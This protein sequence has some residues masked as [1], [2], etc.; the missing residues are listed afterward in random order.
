MNRF[1]G[2]LLLMTA[3][4][5]T[6]AAQEVPTDVAAGAQAPNAGERRYLVQQVGPLA[7][8]QYYADGF[9]ELTP[10]QRLLAYYLAEAGIAG[11]PIYYDQISSYGV[12]LK[13]LLEGI[14]TH[15]QGISPQVLEKI[16]RYTERFWIDHGNYDLDSS[17][18]FLPEFT[19]GE[20][21]AAAHQ[22]LKN[23]ANFGVRTTKAL[24]SRLA[25]L[26]QP[27]FDANFKPVLTAKNPPPGQDLLAASGNNLYENVK[28]DDLEH[29]TE[30]YALNSRVV[31]RGG[32]IIEEVWRAGT[33]DG[34]IPRDAMRHKFTASSSTWKKL[35]R[36]L[37]PSR[38]TFCAS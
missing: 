19:S 6:P 11:D 21:R 23:G 12:E 32:K 18:K 2:V 14:W 20:L 38:Q 9:E 10:Q 7:V 15:P 4:M 29:F 34:R 1:V 5:T 8:I 16:R 30:R 22:A 37:S 13:Q 24:D 27:I 25:R 33:P 28:T 26:E 36:W 35:P 31:K 17:R 3:Y